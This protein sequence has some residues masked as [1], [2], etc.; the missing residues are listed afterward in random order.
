MAGL[1]A[2][3][4]GLGLAGALTLGALAYEGAGG[5]PD[6]A[7]AASPPTSSEQR[8]PTDFFP[9]AGDGA[10]PTPTTRPS[11]DSS[12]EPVTATAVPSAL[13]IAPPED[14][15]GQ[16]TPL[17]PDDLSG[18]TGELETLRAEV[19]EV[20]E[21]ANTERADAGCE[22]LR[23]DR[24]L[25]K[26]AEVHSEDMATRRYMA[27]ESPEGEGP[28]ERAEDAGYEAWSGENVAAGYRSAEAVMAG[29]MDSPGHR[30]NILNCDNRAVGV[31]EVDT[32]WT[33]TFG[34][35]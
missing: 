14:S 7:G 21:L 19:A 12:A 31:A 30:A 34:R 26:A 18:D 28:A 23:V 4:V 27:H 13:D 35:R 9:D 20:V 8:P 6:H 17:P 1:V 15:G 2:L 33:Q 11:P 24:Q 22:P 10:A 29:W 16:E 32:Y 5:T 25:T 3:P